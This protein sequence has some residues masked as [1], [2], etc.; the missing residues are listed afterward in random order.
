MPDM[1]FSTEEKC[2]IGCWWNIMMT[3]EVTFQRPHIIHPRMRKGL[4]ELTD[5]GLLAF[6]DRHG[7]AIWTPTDKMKT[8][9]PR[10]SQKFLE[11]NSFPITTE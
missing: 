5:K 9:K 6:E 3:T 4:D 10:V 1:E 8:H 2:V 11:E 7:I